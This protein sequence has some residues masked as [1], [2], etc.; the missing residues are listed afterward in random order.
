MKIFNREPALFLTAALAAL[1]VF[2]VLAHMDHDHQNALSVGATAVFGIGLAVFTRPIQPAALTG[3]IAT[4]ATAVGAFGFTVSPD[5][6]SAFNAALVAF[7]A[8][9]LTNRVSPSPALAKRS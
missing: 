9:T 2:A 3:G 5:V 7:L 4:L 8:V 6:V 1:Q